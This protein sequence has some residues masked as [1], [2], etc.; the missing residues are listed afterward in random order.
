MT[1]FRCRVGHAYTTESLLNAQNDAYEAALWTALRA[2][3]ER[4]DM[5]SGMARRARERGQPLLEQRYESRRAEIEPHI[6]T[7][8]EMLTDG[9]DVDKQ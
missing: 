9:S 7:L 6:V 4:V 2:L 3:E 8:T 1:R 5:Y